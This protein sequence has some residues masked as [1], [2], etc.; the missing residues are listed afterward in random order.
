M[1]NEPRTCMR[2]PNCEDRSG[3]PP[4]DVDGIP[5]ALVR[6][7]DRD[8]FFREEFFLVVRSLFYLPS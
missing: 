2:M 3:V 4:D 8:E 1:R 6:L 5:A 7:E